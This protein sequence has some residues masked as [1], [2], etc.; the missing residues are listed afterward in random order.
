[1][2]TSRTFLAAFL[3]VGIAVTAGG[4][5]V[6]QSP[7][8]GMSPG[9]MSRGM[10]SDMMGQG[11]RPSVM[12]APGMMQ[13][14]RGPGMMGQ[15]IGSGMM[16]GSGMMA[17][18]G[19]MSAMFGTRVVPMMNLSAED[20][21]GYLAWRLERLGNKRLKLGEIKTEGETI[22]ADIVTVDNSL[23]QRLKVDRRTGAIEYQD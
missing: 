7:K 13:G 17:P 11:M 15:G 2:K 19:G 18:G 3:A 9:M 4:P 1:M 21:Q 5:A 6:A 16:M 8:G 10:G 12:M 22:T 20:V 14:G 23:V